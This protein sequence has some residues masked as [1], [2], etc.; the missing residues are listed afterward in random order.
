[1]KKWSFLPRKLSYTAV[2]V[3]LSFSMLFS[4]CMKSSKVSESTS[5]EGT[6]QESTT[7][8]TVD[9]D[10]NDNEALKEFDEFT[11]KIFKDELSKNGLNL[12]YEIANPETYGIN[13]YDLDIGDYS[14]DSFNESLEDMK[15]Y[16]DKLN[17]FDYDELSQEQQITYDIFKEY[18]MNEIDNF[19][20]HLYTEPL[21]PTIGEQAQL[22][23][24]MAEY[25][26]YR[27]Q[28]VKDYLDILAQVPD[29]FNSIL[30]LEKR[31]SQ[32]GI[33]MSDTSV[34][35][36]TKQCAEFIKDPSTNLLLS[37]FDTKVDALS[38]DADDVKD[39]KATNTDIVNN[40][41]IPAYQALIDG[42]NKLKGTG[43]NNGGLCG[44]DKGKEY[45]EYLIKSSVGSYRTV[46]DIF[47]LIQDEYN[48]NIASYS[49]V[50]SMN[51]D[52]TNE[53]DDYS[54]IKTDDTP[55]NLLNFLKDNIN[56]AFPEGGSDT[57][58]VKTIDKSLEDFVSPAMYLTPAIDKLSEN[59]IY[60]NNASELE[61]SE[62]VVTL[63][64]EGYPGHLYQT[65]YYA[66]TNPS[67][68]R[69]MLSFTGYTEGWATY[70]E[71]YSYIYGGL[72][73][74]A[75]KFNRLNKQISLNVYSQIDIG[76]NYYGWD[77]TK[78]K[79]FIT[80]NY[81]EDVAAEYLDEIYN[82]MVEEP[83]NYLNYYLGYLE[84][85]SLQNTAEHSLGDKFS[86]KEFNKFILD[87]GPAQFNTLQTYL[88]KW[89]ATQ[90]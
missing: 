19:D 2:A 24:V 69:Q 70:A 14:E 62:F 46:D 9:V 28:D 55:E 74:D 49:V 32:A 4:G 23:I 42:L 68:I 56:D 82:S 57:F 15:D 31:K 41:V 18:L 76:I 79:E 84:F 34:D 60:I 27:E 8:A 35:D 25:K 58:S 33:F 1:M 6:T 39:F 72:S 5:A 13:D 53:L 85:E 45:Y 3:V 77:K 16:L 36:I 47:K 29:Y 80:D 87:F 10:V 66:D 26:F 71:I 11:D 48:K 88:D 59:T 86:L 75:M 21:S 90:K 44:F 89:I 7:T 43:T 51:S 17:E 78:T 64:H 81:G 63:A 61:G 22:P 37:T 12:H 83:G 67:L 50:Y 40:N 30:D 54:D 73:D 65:T 20:L 38:L 52:V